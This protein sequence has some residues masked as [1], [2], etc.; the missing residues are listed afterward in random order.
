[1]LGTELLDK[2][3]LTMMKHALPQLAWMQNKYNYLTNMVD[4]RN[5]RSIRWLKALGFRL[6]EPQ[7]FGF[8]HTVIPF[9][10]RA[11]NV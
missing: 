9:E 2:Y 8:Y 11:A 1:M 10:W 6:L 3:P 4:A 7:R 5:T